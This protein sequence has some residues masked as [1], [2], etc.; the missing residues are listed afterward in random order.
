MKTLDGT[1]ST[2][3]IY[4]AYK[5]RLLVTHGSV[6]RSSSVRNL[7]VNKSNL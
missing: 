4:S 3:G 2:E 5:E 6:P 1:E 7:T